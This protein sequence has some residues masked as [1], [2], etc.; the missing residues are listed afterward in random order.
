[1]EQSKHNQIKQLF[2]K[3]R[4]LWFKNRLEYVKQ[5]FCAD[6]FIVAYMISHGVTIVDKPSAVPS[7]KKES[8]VPR[9]CATC[10]NA[11]C[12]DDFCME[13]SE[14]PAD[15]PLWREQEGVDQ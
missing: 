5:G 3:A 8:S 12:T 14:N 7:K 1:M 13:R 10:F 6:D 2:I 4:D 15:C 9:I 11:D